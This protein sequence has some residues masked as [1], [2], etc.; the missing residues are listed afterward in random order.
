MKKIIIAVLGVFAISAGLWFG[1]WRG[2]P[3]QT[4]GDQIIQR[5]GA[6]TL[7][8]FAIGDTGSGNENQMT[9]AAAMEE[10]CKNG[11]KPTGIF[12]LGDN[13]YMDG[14]QSVEDPQWESKVWRPYGSPCLKDVTIYAVL[15]NHDY[16]G[17]PEVQIQMTA[18]DSRWVMPARNYAVRFGDL[19]E[20]DVL[21]SNFVDV[22]FSSLLCARDFF[23]ARIA[24]SP[25]RWRF[26]L[27]H[28]PVISASDKYHDDQFWRYRT[29]IG[30]LLCHSTDLYLSG[31][32]HH[33]EHARMPECQTDFFVIGGGGADVSPIIEGKSGSLFA[34][35]TNGF[36]DILV[37]ERRIE[38]ILVGKDGMVLY[39]TSVTRPK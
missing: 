2:A 27:A 7:R 38:T 5:H 33:L 10:R 17:R 32:A 21:D 35:S 16:K 31:H 28:H 30:S 8:F 36:A 13:F 23:K 26:A 29:L 1:W 4:S 19:L 22:C 20:A 18:K 39:Q 24:A 11:E 25:A 37:N 34:R 12:L 15:G 3:R 14:V 6:A 9:T